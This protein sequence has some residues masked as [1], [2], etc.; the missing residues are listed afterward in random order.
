MQTT[1]N[2]AST[3]GTLHLDRT[4]TDDQ[5]H[6]FSA[7][8]PDANGKYLVWNHHDAETEGKFDRAD[9]ATDLM[10]ELAG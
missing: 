4:A 2:Q 8:G 6:K 7:M 10:L 9:D 3:I 5:G 1:T